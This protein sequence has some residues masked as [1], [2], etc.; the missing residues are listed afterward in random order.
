MK[1]ALCLSGLLH[2][3][4]KAFPFLEKN[5]IDTLHPDVFI[6]TWD[7]EGKRT[8][9]VIHTLNKASEE[10]RKRLLEIL[11]MHTR[12]Q[13]LCVEVCSILRKYDAINYAKEYS[14]RLM[15]EAW[16]TVEP[17][18]KESDAKNKLKSFADYLINREI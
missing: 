16:E 4:E 10:D 13:E 2:G 3:F 14:R 18:L 15:T 8:L 1:I 7:A 17:V 11:G 9:M 6:H 5:L 12:E